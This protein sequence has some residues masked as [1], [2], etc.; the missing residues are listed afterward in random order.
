MRRGSRRSAPG[1]LIEPSLLP[2]GWFPA[3][4]TDVGSLQV[5]YAFKSKCYSKKG[6]RLLRGANIAPG[7]VI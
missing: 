4:L 2:E 7:K 5:G 3:F 1:D 6:V